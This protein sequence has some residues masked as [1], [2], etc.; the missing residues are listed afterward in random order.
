MMPI[1]F[2][3]RARGHVEHICLSQQEVDSVL[4]ALGENRETLVAREIDT[5]PEMKAAMG[6]V[7]D[8]AIVIAECLKHP[9]SMNADHP[10]IRQFFTDVGGRLTD[11]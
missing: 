6:E 2:L 10:A 4:S 9:E 1:I 8:N 5:V 11:G 7:R 3:N